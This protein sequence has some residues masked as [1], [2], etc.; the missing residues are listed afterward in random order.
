MKLYRVT[1]DSLY[2]EIIFGDLFNGKTSW[3]HNYI[4]PAGTLLYEMG[5]DTFFVP[6][7]GRFVSTSITAAPY[8]CIEEI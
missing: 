4:M 5:Q 7:I 6:M 1:T 8:E 3:K 2:S